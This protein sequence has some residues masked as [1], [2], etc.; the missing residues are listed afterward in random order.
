M[1]LIYSDELEKYVIKVDNHANNIGDYSPIDEFLADSGMKVYDISRDENIKVSDVIDDALDMATTAHKKHM[2]IYCACS[3]SVHV[4]VLA[5]NISKLRAKLSALDE[6]LD[7]TIADQVERQHSD[8]HCPTCS[9][10][11]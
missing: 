3:D 9:C 8:N 10:N 11:D 1:R 6:K 7:Q 2:Q 5:E 4:Y